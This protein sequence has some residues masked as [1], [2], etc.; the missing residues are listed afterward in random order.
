M[1]NVAKLSGFYCQKQLSP[2]SPHVPAELNAPDYL[3]PPVSPRLF[4]LGMAPATMGNTHAYQ[5]L[6]W[7]PYSHYQPLLT[8]SSGTHPHSTLTVLL[9]SKISPALASHHMALCGSPAPAQ[10]F[11][12][13][14]DNCHHPYYLCTSLDSGSYG[15]VPTLTIWKLTICTSCSRCLGPKW[16]LL[17]AA[18]SLLTTLCSLPYQTGSGIRGQWKGWTKTL[19][20]D[21]REV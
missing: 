20:C 5:H 14:S 17:P 6:S 13:R 9:A 3:L 2:S 8:V 11:T 18:P 7:E 4:S 19:K 1:L 12:L 21:I 10:G 16:L 15:L